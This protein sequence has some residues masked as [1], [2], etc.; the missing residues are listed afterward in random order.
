MPLT[1]F[2]DL[3]QLIPR[4]EPFLLFHNFEDLLDQLNLLFPVDVPLFEVSGRVLPMLF[5][6]LLLFELRQFSFFFIILIKSRLWCIKR[7]SRCIEKRDSADILALILRCFLL[8]VYRDLEIHL[9]LLQLE[10]FLSLNVSCCCAFRSRISGFDLVFL[11]EVW[12]N[13]VFF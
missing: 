9:L 8:G 10:L 6:D 5:V 7:N 12:A 11:Y 1:D 2:L 4:F 13:Q 3:H